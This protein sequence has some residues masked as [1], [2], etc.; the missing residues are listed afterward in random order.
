MTAFN[1]PPARVFGCRVLELKEEGVSEEEAMAVADVCI[2]FD[3][4]P[5]S[6]FLRN[7]ISSSC[8]CSCFHPF[9]KFNQPLALVCRWNI[10]QTKK[11]KGWHMLD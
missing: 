5:E 10:G 6:I 9:S 4:V 11:P 2:S 3:R 8:F 7:I 1:P